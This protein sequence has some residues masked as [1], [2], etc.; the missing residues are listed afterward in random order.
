MIVNFYAA[1]CSQSLSLS[2]PIERLAASSRGR[3]KVV[4]VEMG[5]Q[6]ARLCA[7][8]N[9]QRVP[10]TLVFQNGEVRDRIFGAL[11]GGTK[12]DAAGTSCVGLTTLDNLSGMLEGLA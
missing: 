11:T 12:V 9:V 2:E 6:T 3:A 10:T 5:P 7:Q 4:R 8:Y 1:W